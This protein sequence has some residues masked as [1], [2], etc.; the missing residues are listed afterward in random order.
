MKNKLF[1]STV[2]F[3]A[4][5][6]FITIGCKKQGVNSIPVITT[7]SVTN[8]TKTT[9][10]CGGNLTDDGGETLLARGI[11]WDTLPVPSPVYD[12]FLIHTTR[13]ATTVGEFYSAIKNLLPNRVY[14]VRAYARNHTGWAYGDIKTF[15]TLKEQ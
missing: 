12:S 2:L 1:M 11:C 10:D 9:A 15:K 5:S 3:V 8:I 14:Y 7:A 13:E 4:F 6:F